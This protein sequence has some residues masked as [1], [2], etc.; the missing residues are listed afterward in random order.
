M[1]DRVDR[2]PDPVSLLERADTLRREATALLRETGVLETF[3]RL[4]DVH[5]VG[6]YRL[7]T[8]FRPDIDIIILAGRPRREEA[9]AVSKV[10]LDGGQFQTIGFADTM[11]YSRPGEPRGYY[12]QLIAP[13]GNRWW[14]LD[15]WYLRPEEDRSIAPTLRFSQLLRANEPARETI[16]ELKAHFFDGT[17]YRD[18]VTGP[19]IYDAVLNQGVTSTEA[20]MESQ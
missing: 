8:M 15:V 2:Y 5:F 9:V 18:G 6:S 17:K 4:G 19:K 7:D 16:L 20:L 10:L 3:D 11:S 13:R 14:K 1:L 12:W